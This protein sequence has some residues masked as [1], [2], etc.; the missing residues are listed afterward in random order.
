MLKKTIQA[1][2]PELPTYPSEALPL[3]SIDGYSIIY[4][5]AY[6][7]LRMYEVKLL[8]QK[9]KDILGF[10]LE[11]LPDTVRIGGRKII[12]ASSNAPNG[13]EGAI[14]SF[15]S[16]FDYVVGTLNGNIILGGNNF[17]ADMRAI[18]DFINNYLGYD[19]VED[20]IIAEPKAEIAGV[21]IK[22]YQEPLI[23]LLGSSFATSPYTEQ[24]AVR[25]MAKAGFNMTIIDSFRYS[26][27]QFHNFIKWCS[28]YEI[29][30][31]LIALPKLSYDVDRII[32][33]ALNY[34]DCPVIWGHV[35]R[36]EPREEMFRGIAEACRKY[37]E[38]PECIGWKPYVNFAGFKHVYD[39]AMARF[40]YFDTFPV[41]SIDRYFAN[42]I[43]DHYPNCI[44][45]FSGFE[46]FTDR[47]KLNG[48]DFWFYIECY[49]NINKGI[50]S[51]KQLRWSSYVGLSFGANGIQYYQ[52]GDCSKNY[53][54]EGDWTGGSLI[55]WDFSKNEAWY[56]AKQ[57]N[58]ELLKLAEVYRNY[59]HDFS[60]ILNANSEAEQEIAHLSFDHSSFKDVLADIQDEK[61]RYLVGT[62]SKICGT[63]KAFTLVNLETITADKYRTD[64]TTVKVRINGENIKFYFE[65]EPVDVAKDANGYYDVPMGNGYC[66]FVTVE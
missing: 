40:D 3:T 38:K 24:Y 25:D 5:A 47:A 51:E 1:N 7:E 2:A 36:D 54:A 60:F 34:K 32:E 55:N 8:Q 33:S 10:E 15:E 9:I 29:K 42:Q 58:E 19:D 48:Q 20:K 11:I 6:D 43:F 22:I 53:T 59:S 63:G 56:H 46:K 45:M 4:P 41:L 13:V 57:N 21:N 31:M 44:D 18:Y 65:G 12:L 35:L 30:L 37:L 14:E 62:F 64:E 52:Y 50:H 27:E 61:T 16:G 49:N 23:T 17:Y 39:E 26:K 66:W 28:R